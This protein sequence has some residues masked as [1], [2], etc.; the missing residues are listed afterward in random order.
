MAS[1]IRQTPDSSS[2][3]LIPFT[4]KMSPLPKLTLYRHN[5]G[6]SLVTHILLTELSIP[7]TDIQLNS[8]ANNKYA[9]TD[10][11]FTHEDY[12]PRCLP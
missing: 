10:G 6:C 7:H 1:L 11:S 8:D 9:A 3:I 2:S 12:P 5:G 4:P